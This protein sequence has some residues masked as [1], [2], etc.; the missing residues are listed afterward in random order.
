MMENFFISFNA[1]APLASYI[2]IGI[3]IKKLKIVDDDFLKRLNAVIFN[4]FFPIIMFSNVYNTDF[5]ASADPA[6][7]AFNV[8]FTLIFTLVLFLT[9]PRFIKSRATCGAF[10]QGAYRS[11]IVLFGIPLTI[12][13]FGQ[14]HVGMISVSITFIT[15][16]YNILAVILL[17]YF[18]GAGADIKVL[19]KNIFK[20]PLIRGAIAGIIF[21]LLNI[22]APEFF[23]TVVKNVANSSTIFA[24]IVLGGSLKFASMGSNL[25]LIILNSFLRLI[26][27]PA[28][29]VGIAYMLGLRGMELFTTLIITGTPVAA[30]SYAMAQNM[31]SDYEL[32]AQMVATTTVLSVFTMFISI[33]IFFTFNLV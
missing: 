13:L 29:A 2:A 17:E 32:A 5:S 21:N 23:Q 18:R 11:N 28:L 24:L 10:I 30:A 12:S 26:A 14:D 3:I 19:V 31:E 4:G 15:P 7:V 33:M 1:V 16:L 27:V 8:S 9:V 6:V 22:P 25:K 20:N